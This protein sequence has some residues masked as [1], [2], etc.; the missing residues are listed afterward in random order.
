MTCFLSRNVIRRT[1]DGSHSL[2]LPL[3][4]S[5][6]GDGSGDDHECERKKTSGSGYNERKGRTR[7]GGIKKADGM[8]GGGAD[9]DCRGHI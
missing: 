1:S 6:L 8:G 9:A 4:S 5:S 2:S 7:K 3:N